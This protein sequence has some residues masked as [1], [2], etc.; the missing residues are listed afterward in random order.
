VPNDLAAMPF[1][2]GHGTGNDF[3]LLPDHDGS[4][5]GERVPSRL[6]IDLC[7]R[8]R[9][10]GADGVIRVVR[11]GVLG[12]PRAPGTTWFMDYLNADGTIAE[13][14]G[15]GVR[16]LARYLLEEGLVSDEEAGVPIGTRA[17]VLTVRTA[18]EHTLTVDMGPARDGLSGATVT[19]SHPA[20]TGPGVAVAMPNPHAVLPVESLEAVGVLDRAP[21]VR[22]AE[23][24]PDGVNVE[25]VERRG[26]DALAMRVHERGVGETL[27]CGTG[28]CAAA[29]VAMREDEAQPGSTYTVDVPGGRLWVTEDDA[30]SLHLRGPAV[31][32]ARGTITPGAILR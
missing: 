29:W 19:S 17:G 8:R 20:V 21:E 4:R 11:T 12:L 3:V 16:V 1:A 32:V 24:F 14:C 9:G 31:I 18:P 26:P 30:G 2:K 6:V 23:L 27:S 10:I 25:L 15:N 5:Y 22:P 13:M 7:D 28:V